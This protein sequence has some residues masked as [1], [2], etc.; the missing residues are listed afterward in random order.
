MEGN[1]HEPLDVLHVTA[2]LHISHFLPPYFLGILKGFLN[3]IISYLNNI[4]IFSLKLNLS[5]LK[6]VPLKGREY[7][8]ISLVK[9]PVLGPG[10]EI[11]QIYINCGTNQCGF[12]VFL[13]QQRK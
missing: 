10:S 3:G 5:A 2:I 9:F 6:Y 7:V 4:V 11:N 12:V 8:L 13:Q 1:L